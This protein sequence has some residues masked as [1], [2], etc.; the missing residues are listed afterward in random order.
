M[1]SARYNLPTRMRCQLTEACVAV[2]ELRLRD[3][4]TRGG[5]GRGGFAIQKQLEQCV[6]AVSGCCTC[7]PKNVLLTWKMRIY[8][9]RISH[10]ALICMFTEFFSLWKKKLWGFYCAEKSI[11]LVMSSYLIICYFAVLRYV[12]Y[13]CLAV[14]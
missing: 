10:F 14:L 9:E 12:P 6:S 11:V 5:E 7:I 13:G 1:L 3:V 2:L 8:T 4:R